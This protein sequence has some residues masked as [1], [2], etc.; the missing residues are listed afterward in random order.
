MPLMGRARHHE[1][2]A[3]NTTLRQC[4]RSVQTELR[5][6]QPWVWK[7]V[8]IGKIQAFNW[9]WWLDMFLTSPLMVF[10]RFSVV[11][12]GDMEGMEAWWWWFPCW[13]KCRMYSCIEEL[14]P[15]VLLHTYYGVS[16]YIVGV[17]TPYVEPE[18]TILRGE[19]TCVD[20]WGRRHLLLD[21]IIETGCPD[22][23]D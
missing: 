21:W 22:F 18:T 10:G 7:N 16:W 4:H 1:N 11:E 23:I 5:W 19:G 12:N 15:Q 8:W 20:H 6:W 13:K 17:Y 3:H 2:H 14:W 9:F